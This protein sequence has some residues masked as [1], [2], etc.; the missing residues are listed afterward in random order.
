MSVVGDGVDAAVRGGA[1][2]A[3]AAISPTNAELPAPVRMTRR[4]G[5][6]RATPRRNSGGTV[7]GA[8]RDLPPRVGL[9]PDLE[10]GCAAVWSWAGIG[11]VLVIATP[12][13][14]CGKLCG[15]ARAA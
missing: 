7:V 3:G 4:S 12:V 10:N 14:R 15:M 5:T 9:L 11:R 8:R 13:L 2:S 6:G 1:R